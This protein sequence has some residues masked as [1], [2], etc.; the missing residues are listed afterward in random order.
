MASDI[1]FFRKVMGQFTTGVT[2]ATTRTQT[3]ISGLTVNSFTSVSLRPLLILICIDLRSHTLAELRESG[4]FA[5]N[6]LRQEQED[7]SNCFAISSEERYANFCHATYS[8]AATGSPILDGAMGFLDTRIVAEYPGGDHVIFMGQ[9]E[10]M[11][12]N[13]QTFFLPS[14]KSEQSTSP[15][16]LSAEI[17]PG[18]SNGHTATVNEQG[19]PLLFYHGQYYHL[20]RQYQHQH[21][22][23]IPAHANDEQK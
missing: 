3:G 17:S 18:S 16:S 10:A 13:G 11:G 14:A 8:T 2:V 23:I 6:I 19:S 22:T 4:V 12:Y 15:E 20:S 5:V 7:L 1:D 9:V 21:P